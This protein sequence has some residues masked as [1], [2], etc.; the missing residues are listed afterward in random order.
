MA[1]P[2]DLPA[3][4]ALV[5]TAI[6]WGG[7]IVFQKYALGSFSAVEVSVLRGLGALA[8]L[9][10]LW[11]WQE[12]GTVAISA[13]D[14]GVF[15]VLG[16]G[17]LGNHL[18]TLFGLRYIGAA[19]AGVIIGASPA[20]TAFLSSVLIRD[21]PFS[22]VWA[23]CALSFAGVALVSAGG[24]DVVAGESPWLGGAL[25][26]LGLVSWALY[27]IGGRRTMERFSPLTVNW[28]TL[29]LSI[30]LQIPLLWTDQ[31][32]VVAGAASVP[33]SGWMALLYLIVFA[34]ALGQ[35]AWLYG[36]KGV[37]PSRAGVFVNLIPVSALVFSAI[38]LGESIGLKEVAGIVLILAGVWLVNWQ[39]ARA[40]RS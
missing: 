19:A 4:G 12:G 30:L 20:I 21:V 32:M 10:P 24:G 22:A 36:V 25:V 14:W 23:G 16:L 8:I 29:G 38:I 15:A 40:A 18:L 17:V 31:K 3:Y 35:Q 26:V 27:S 11:W 5:T 2:S 37:G 1:K 13:R 34:T 7:S 28:T 6:V 9:I 33:I 39:S